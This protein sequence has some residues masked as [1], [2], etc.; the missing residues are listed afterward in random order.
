MEACVLVEK[1]GICDVWNPNEIRRPQEKFVERYGQTLRFF[2]IRIGYDIGEG[3]KFY[4]WEDRWSGEWPLKET[5]PNVYFLAENR[6]A[7]VAKCM[8]RSSNSV[9]WN[10]MLRRAAYDWEIPQICSPMEMLD[11]VTMATNQF[12]KRR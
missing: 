5:F 12:G 1:Y 11:S 3:D 8:G 2:K 9:V 4:F 7:K 6:L 10:T